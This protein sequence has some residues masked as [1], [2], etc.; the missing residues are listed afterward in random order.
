MSDTYTTSATET[1]TIVHARHI[2][3]KVATDLM[4][5]H[6]FYSSPS[7]SDIDAYEAE[8]VHLLKHN[9]VRS[10]V[11][12]F[13]RNGKWTAASVKYVALPDGTLATD[14]DPGKIN[15][16]LDIDGASFW[17]FLE[18]NG[19]WD[20][21][22]SAEQQAIREASPIKRVGATSPNLEHGYWAQDRSYVAGGRGMGR[23]TPQ[24]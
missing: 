19:H 1:F 12:G 24:S 8:M 5:F 15:P 7:T 20:A 4:R 16:G 22:T 18:Y 21:L 6:R 2:A 11:Y 9:V 17:S 14:D 10:V 23:S 3:S 13:R